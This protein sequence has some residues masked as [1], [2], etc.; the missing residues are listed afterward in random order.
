LVDSRLIASN[1][2]EDDELAISGDGKTVKIKAWELK[3]VQ[4]R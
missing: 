1:P 3:E 4:K 2:S